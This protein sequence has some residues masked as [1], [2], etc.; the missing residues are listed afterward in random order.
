MT[1]GKGPVAGW[2]IGV[3]KA[4]ILFEAAGC[5]KELFWEAARVA[6]SKLPIR[7]VPIERE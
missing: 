6:N 1:E 4:G 2:A 7:A 3:P 5:S